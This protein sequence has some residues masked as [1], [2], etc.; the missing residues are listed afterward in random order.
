[1]VKGC[2]SGQIGFDAVIFQ[3]GD[4]LDDVS[5]GNGLGLRSHL[6]R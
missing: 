5:L 4:G 6:V 2:V 3:I 1:L